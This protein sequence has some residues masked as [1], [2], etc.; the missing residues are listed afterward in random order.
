MGRGDRKLAPSVGGRPCACCRACCLLMGV[1]ECEWTGMGSDVTFWVDLMSVW[2]WVRN[3][4]WSLLPQLQLPSDLMEGG[5]VGGLG[6]ARHEPLS[7]P[8]YVMTTRRRL[9]VWGGAEC[10]P[11]AVVVQQNDGS[12]ASSQTMRAGRRR[13]RSKPSMHHVLLG[14][15]GRSGRP[16]PSPMGAAER[17]TT[18][19]PCGEKGKTDNVNGPTVVGPYN[20]VI[21]NP[22]GAARAEAE[23]RIHRRSRLTRSIFGTPAFCLDPHLDRLVS[24]ANQIRAPID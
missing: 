12:T 21:F 5:G 16:G 7:Q 22:T 23:Q 6:H 3:G 15:V 8:V 2:G 20:D 14:S 11:W 19:G 9:L 24:N 18:K 1:N 4:P 13:N 17:R 10:G